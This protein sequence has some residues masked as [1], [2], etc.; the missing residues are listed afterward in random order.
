MFIAIE[1]FRRRGIRNFSRPIPREPVLAITFCT[2]THIIEFMLPM[3][4]RLRCG[5]PTS[6]L[7][8]M[9]SSEPG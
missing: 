9:P 4:Q 8:E 3:S 1:A 7:A 5:P 2:V 6:G